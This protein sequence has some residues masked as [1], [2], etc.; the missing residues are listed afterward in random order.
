ML[1]FCVR[2]GQSEFNAEGRIQG[3][4][5]TPLSPLGHR[6]GRVV[7]AALARLQ[8]DVVFSSPL[9]RAKDTA[10]YVAEAANVEL[11]CEDRLKELNAGIFQG[12]LWPDIERDLP[13]VAAAWRK[14]DPDYRLPDGESRRDLMLRGKAALE[15]IRD[16]GFQRIAVVAHGGLLTAA[17]KA[18]LDIPGDRSPFDLFNCSI[19]RC[20]WADQFKL[21]TL[22][23]VEHLR[24]FESEGPTLGMQ[25]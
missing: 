20:T 18:L 22:N 23:E 7:A 21:L 16:S 5:D 3:Q 13:E 19:S 14:H 11:L 24:E 15:A 2:H 10:R 4:I 25:L 6:Q 12:K 8:L 1:L 17:F 9:C